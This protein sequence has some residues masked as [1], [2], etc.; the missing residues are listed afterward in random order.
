M[1]IPCVEIRHI[2]AK[3]NGIVF[4]FTISEKVGTG[5]SELLEFSVKRKKIIIEGDNEEIRI[6]KTITK[7]EGLLKEFGKNHINGI[8]WIFRLSNKE[9]I[10]F[11]QDLL[12]YIDEKTEKKEHKKIEEIK[13][14]INNAEVKL[15]DW[16]GFCEE[17]E[18]YDEHIPDD[19]NAYGDIPFPSH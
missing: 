19:P 14:T 8:K 1:E 16:G 2:S 4:Y 13:S 10:K 7:G 11:I 18:D 3:A 17:D 9:R 5:E 6:Y 15:E 12:D